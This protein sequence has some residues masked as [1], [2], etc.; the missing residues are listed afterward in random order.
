MIGRD[1]RPP[2]MTDTER[3]AAER[4]KAELDRLHDLRSAGVKPFIAGHGR[5]G[6][7]S[8]KADSNC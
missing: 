5:R 7:D 2:V 4:A 6:F 1:H 3:A 8:W